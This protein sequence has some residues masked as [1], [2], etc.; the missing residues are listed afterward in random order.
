M[1]CSKPFKRFSWPTQ[2][3]GDH[4]AQDYV[5]PVGGGNH[6]LTNAMP[7]YIKSLHAAGI[8]WAGG[9]IDNKSKGLPYVVATIIIQDPYTGSSLGDGRCAHYKSGTE[10]L[11]LSSLS[12]FAM[13]EQAASPLWL[14][15]PRKNFLRL[16]SVA[17]HHRS[18]MTSILKWRK[19]THHR[20]LSRMG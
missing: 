11:L 5:G 7:A 18:Q 6:V 2:A 15:S 16:D 13:T 9:Y 17:E 8:K 14:P 4:A 1:R 12:C 3:R 10:R 19:N 20:C